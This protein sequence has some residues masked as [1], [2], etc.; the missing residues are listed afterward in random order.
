MIVRVLSIGTY[1]NDGDI[2]HL[3]AASAAP[4]ASEALDSGDPYAFTS[5]ETGAFACN[6][7]LHPHEQEQIDAI[8]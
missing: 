4:F 1:D 3:V 2:P 6:R 8:G 5:T 7:G